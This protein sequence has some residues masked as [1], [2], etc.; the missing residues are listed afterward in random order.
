MTVC[1]LCCHFILSRYRI[2]RQY[3]AKIA[4]LSADHVIYMCVFVCYH[5]KISR[6]RIFSQ[7]TAKMVHLS[8]DHIIYKCVLWPFCHLMPSRCHIFL[9]H[10]YCQDRASFNRSCYLYMYVCIYLFVIF[11]RVRITS[12]VA[13]CQEISSFSRSYHLH[14]CTCF[15]LFCHELATLCFCVEFG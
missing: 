9:Q 1:L 11:C 2:F 6:C 7:H 13:Y 15:Y 14:A 8:A 10:I 5:F 3:N 12:F 4:Q